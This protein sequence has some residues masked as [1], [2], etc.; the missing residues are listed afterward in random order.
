MSDEYHDPEWDCTDD[1]LD[2]AKQIAEAVADGLLREFNLGKGPLDPKGDVV[3]II[4]SV[5]STNVRAA[6]KLAAQGLI[7]RLTPGRDIPD[8]CADGRIDIMEAVRIVRELD[9][10]S[11]D[12]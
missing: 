10:I 1:A 7:E 3:K 6:L 12:D 5:V 11:D 8:G 4:E 2:A 9:Y